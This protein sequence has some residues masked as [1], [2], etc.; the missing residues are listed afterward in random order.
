MSKAQLTSLVRFNTIPSLDVLRFFAFLAVFIS[1]SILFLPAVFSGSTNDFLHKYFTIGDLGVSTFFVLSGFLI[2]TILLTE[3][4]RT[5]TIGIISFYI[6]RI[7]RI[8]PLYLFIVIMGAYIIPTL[9]H[10]EVFAFPHTIHGIVEAW[11]LFTFT[12]N[13]SQYPDFLKVSVILGVLWSISVEEQF[14]LIWPWCIKY[15]RA[16]GI[17]IVLIAIILISIVFRYIHG[18]NRSV[19]EYHTLSV[20]SDIALGSLFA[21]LF[22][23]FHEYMRSLGS[24]TTWSLGIIS[25]GIMIADIFLRPELLQFKVFVALE[26]ICFALAVLGLIML[27][28]QETVHHF[29]KQR[30]LVYLGKISYGLYMYHIIAMMIMLLI[31]KQIPDI[32]AW[33]LV[34]GSFVITIIL[35]TLSYQVFERPILR[36]KNRAGNSDAVSL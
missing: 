4:N 17:R 13:L 30:I 14:Y 6:R 23:T 33:I 9:V 29:F 15:L 36:L 1:H 25:I 22:V 24:R 7:L 20:M 8:W 31:A 2:T 10:Q 11:R 28:L 19:V 18:D 27:L 16:Q 32:S 3:K 5:Q 12:F 26:P 34:L 35:A 21:G